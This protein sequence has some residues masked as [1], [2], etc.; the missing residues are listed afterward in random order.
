MS[1]DE[2]MVKEINLYFDNSLKEN[3]AILKTH[4]M[5]AD[6]ETNFDFPPED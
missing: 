1:N 2:E 3:K 4:P 6:L 5:K